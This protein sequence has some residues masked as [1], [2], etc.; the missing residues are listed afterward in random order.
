MESMAHHT[1]ASRSIRLDGPIRILSTAFPEADWR[2]QFRLRRR[3][4]R[5]TARTPSSRK[6]GRIKSTVAL[7]NAALDLAGPRADAASTPLE[8]AKRRRDGT[9]IA[10]LAVLPM[11]RRAFASLELGRSVLVG[12]NRIDIALPGELTKN[13]LP[14]EAT[15]PDVVAPLLRRYLEE[16][17]PYFLS[18]GNRRHEFLWTTSNGEPLQSNYLGYRISKATAATLGTKISPH[19]FRDAAATSLARLSPKDALLIRPLLG[20]ADFATAERHYIQATMIEAGRAY[21]AVVAGLKEGD[22]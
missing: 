19:L 16:V 17:R 11:R 12:A 20:H 4:L 13:G 15:V 9:M 22:P 10:V 14:W 2:P 18:R 21:A 1:P 7:L 5:H 6:A 3:A 8:A